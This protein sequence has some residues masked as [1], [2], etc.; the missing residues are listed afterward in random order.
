MNCRQGDLAI[1]GRTSFDWAREH[2]GKIVRVVTAY[3]HESWICEP[4]LRASDD[5]SDIA[6]GDTNLIP[7]RGPEADDEILIGKP[8]GD[9][10][11]A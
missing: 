8:V 6:W 3:D 7:I 10:V 11:A 9:E 2:E 1:I 5:G 4:R